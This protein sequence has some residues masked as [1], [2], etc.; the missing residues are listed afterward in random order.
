MDAK[1]IIGSAL[2]AILILISIQYYRGKWLGSIAGYNSLPK[3][4]RKDIDI[5]PYALRVSL[6]SFSLGLLILAV[7]FEDRMRALNVDVFNAILGFMILFAAIAF[8]R[9]VKYIVVNNR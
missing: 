4:V 1:E 3:E 7:A 2:S 8:F 6:S 9:M 5:R